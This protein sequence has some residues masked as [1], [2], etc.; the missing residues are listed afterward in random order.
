MQY[1]IKKRDQERIDKVLAY[2]TDNPNY[3]LE[4]YLNKW[5]LLKGASMQGSNYMISC[6]FHGTDSSPSMS[7]DLKNNRFRCFG[8]SAKGGL[9]N[10]I[11]EYSNKYLGTDLNFWSVLEMFLKEDARMRADLKF[12]TIY[13][14]KSLKELRQMK[15]AELGD[16]AMLPTTYSEVAS[17]LKRRKISIDEIMRTLYLIQEGLTP[18]EVFKY[19]TDGQALQTSSLDISALIK[20][21]K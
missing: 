13:K 1:K 14:S 2:I 16:R 11:I 4:V 19:I 10:F 18:Q 12:G 17:M 3:N 20:G 21:G 15:R 7:I 6:P 8:C 5:G 9:V